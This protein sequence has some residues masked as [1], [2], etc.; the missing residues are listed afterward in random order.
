M[1]PIRPLAWEPTYAMGVAL[2]NKIRL[3]FYPCGQIEIGSILFSI[4]LYDQ[5]KHYWRGKTMED[6]VD[7]YIIRYLL[8]V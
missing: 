1:A 5:T 7:M 6:L 8:F 4:L 2:K 3:S